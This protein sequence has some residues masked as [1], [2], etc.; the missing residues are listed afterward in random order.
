MSATKEKL[1]LHPNVRKLGHSPTVAINEH[2]AELREAGRRVFR[3]GLGQSPF[4]VPESVVERLRANAGQKDYLP[5]RGLASLR[6]AVADYH[7]RRH[8]VP[9]RAQDV[10]VG[11]GSKELMFLLQ[12]AFQGE[13]VIPT[14]AWVSYAPQAQ[15]LGRRV[16]FVETSYES[17]W[18]LT[19]A[20]LEEASARDPDCPRVLVLNYPGNPT[21]VTYDAN[22]L[23]AIARVAQ[24][25]DV[26]VLSDEIYGEL[27]FDGHHV[28]IARFYPEGTIISSGLSKWCGAGG[29]RLGT[30]AFPPMLDW[31]AEAMAAVASETYTSVS[32]PIQH[33]A[34][35]AFVGGLDIERYLT[36][37]RR[38]LQSLMTTV[39]SRLRES[40]AR[41]TPIDGAFYAFPDFTPV[42]NQLHARGIRTSSELCTHLLEDTGVAVLP[43]VVFGR[44]E[45]EL[46]LRI[47]CV[48]FDGARALADA[49]TS[50]DRL[51]AAFLEEHCSNVLEAVRL[52][53]AWIAG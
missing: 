10:L 26:I 53:S 47:A 36:N 3:L 33:A 34:V 19:A 7:R 46:T 9:V 49:E 22:E 29:W 44:P 51:D 38:I 35:R 5:V 16:R 20:Q 25:W 41:H 43:G 42:A 39:A 31:L 32:A 24:K 18:K 37:T 21:G 30:F 28:S 12:V 48:D 4:P 40:G 2:C 14:P 1:P 52:M 15:I 50:A 45:S 23:E 27:H 17:G 8:G 6:E 11:P 13:L